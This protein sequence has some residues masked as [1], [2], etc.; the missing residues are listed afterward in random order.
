MSGSFA[1]AVGDASTTICMDDCHRAIVQPN[2]REIFLA[3]NSSMDTAVVVGSSVV[4][5][6]VTVVDSSVEEL[7]DLLLSPALTASTL[8]SVA[9]WHS[10]NSVWYFAVSAASDN[11]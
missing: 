3:H 9:L 6:H 5:V 4:V 7:V 10:D 11:C 8:C 2:A 1:V